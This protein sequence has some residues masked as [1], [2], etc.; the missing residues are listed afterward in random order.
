LTR[1]TSEQIARLVK[2]SLAFHNLNKA[3]EA[4]LG[5]SLVQYHLLFNLRDMPG[6]SPQSLARIV[7]MHPSTLTQ[8]LKRLS[9]K[10]FLFVG[11]DPRDSRKKMVTLTLLGKSAV[12]RFEGGIEKLLKNANE[13]DFQFG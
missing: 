5:L 1:S 4:A 6:S 2:M 13:E 7:G 8:S 10:Q 11:E 12:D 9:K 3:V